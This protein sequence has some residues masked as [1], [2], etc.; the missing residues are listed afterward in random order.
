MARAGLSIILIAQNESA[1]IA[2]CLESVRWADEIVVVDGGSADDTVA[3]ARR[4]TDRVFVNPWPGYAAQKQFSLDHATREW[5]F[6]LDADETVTPELRAEIESLLAGSPAHDGYTVPRL[7]SFLGHT[8]RHGGWYPDRQLRLFRRAR[9]R[10]SERRVHEGFLVDGS[11][12]R[13]GNDLL[14]ETHPTLTDSLARVNRYTSLDAL[15]RASRRRVGVLDLLLR[16]PVTFIKKYVAQAGFL[17]GMPGLVLA[18][19]SAISKFSLYAK[20]W[21]LQRG[22][23]DP[24]GQTGHH[25]GRTP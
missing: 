20:T 5:V 25:D 16:P 19:M 23:L 24:G 1:R 21:E 18:V 7:S 4:Y 12:G 13:L 11:V 8:M 17:D 15:D 3:I 14:H 9:G 2:A 6:S 10:L 22:R